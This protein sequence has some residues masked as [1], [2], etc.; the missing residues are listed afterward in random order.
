VIGNGRSEIWAPILAFIWR[1]SK[2]FQETQVI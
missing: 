1:E 2:E